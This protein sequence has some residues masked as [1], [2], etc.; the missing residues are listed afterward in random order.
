MYKQLIHKSNLI[1]AIELTDSEQTLIQ[2]S[3]MNRSTD[4]P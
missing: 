2:H 4:T 1:P 3:Q